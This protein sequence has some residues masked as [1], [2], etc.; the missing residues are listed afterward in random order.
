[1]CFMPDGNEGLS[2]APTGEL[3]Q[4][5]I[6]DIARN[7]R[8]PRQTFDPVKIEQLAASLQEIGLQVPITVYENPRRGRKPYV[9]LDGERRFR[10][11][12]E[13]NWETI[14]AL[15]VPPPSGKENAIRMFNIHTEQFFAD[16]ELLQKCHELN[17]SI[18][19]YKE[20]AESFV[21]Y[22]SFETVEDYIYAARLRLTNATASRILDVA[23]NR[24]LQEKNKTRKGVLLELLVA[25]MLS[26]VEGFEITDV[27]ISNRS[28][29][30]DVLVH[31][32]NVGGALG[33]SPLV[34]AEAKNWKD[35][36]DVREYVVFVRKLQS[37]H[38]RARLGYLITTS[39]FTAGVG[40]ERR[41][42]SMN[43]TLVVLVDG[44]SLP[45][46]WRDENGI[47]ACVERAT[48]KAAI[49]A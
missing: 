20:K 21:P 13:N 14:P 18:L 40:A 39:K 43:E 3:K 9:L 22:R 48:M 44:K 29:Q 35:P 19:L 37:R 41:R 27:G 15:V 1:M 5:K 11:A 10:A 36:V 16:E 46:I 23:L 45:L 25:V 12:K 42:E 17:A 6:D 34:I 38:G 7:E 24:A 2:G 8:N 47:S 49:G 28:Q 30:M 32:R 4:I 33:N 26:Q 31:N